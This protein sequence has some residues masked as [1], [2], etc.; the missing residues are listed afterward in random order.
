MIL[1]SILILIAFIAGFWFCYLLKVKKKIVG[2]RNTITIDVQ[3]DATQFK[4]QMS[5]V[6]DRIESIRKLQKEINE[7]P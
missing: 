1:Q 2:N 4:K 3:C 6:A 5:E 7:R